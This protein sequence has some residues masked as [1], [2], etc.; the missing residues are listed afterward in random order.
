MYVTMVPRRSHNHLMQFMQYS[1]SLTNRDHHRQFSYC[2]QKMGDSIL[3]GNL[4][5]GKARVACKLH[6]LG[7]S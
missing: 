7:R 4:A 2:M 3:R 1:S 5:D 6:F